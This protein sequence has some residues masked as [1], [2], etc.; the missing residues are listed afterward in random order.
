MIAFVA[1]RIRAKSLSLADTKLVLSDYDSVISLLRAG[2]IPHAKT[3][4]EGLTPDGTRIS[5]ADKDALLAEIN[6]YLGQ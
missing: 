5:Q 6:A 1:A 4:V 2:S 3:E